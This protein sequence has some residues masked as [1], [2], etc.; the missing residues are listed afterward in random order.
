MQPA[1]VVCETCFNISNSN[2]MLDEIQRMCNIAFH[3]DVPDPE[4]Q[5]NELYR[6][7][8]FG[9]GQNSVTSVHRPLGISRLFV[10][11]NKL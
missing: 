3:G 6:R 5:W 2:H 7:T 1:S 4:M 11:R 10:M 8:F 9:V